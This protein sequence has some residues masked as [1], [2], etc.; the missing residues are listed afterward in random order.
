MVKERIAFVPTEE[1][2]VRYRMLRKRLVDEPGLVNISEEMREKLNEILDL[3]N[4]GYGVQLYNLIVEDCHYNVEVRSFRDR[5]KAIEIAKEISHERNKHPEYL[6]EDIIEGYEFHIT[7][8]CE[9]DC[10]SVV[11]TLLEK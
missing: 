1:Q 6:K 4:D 10:V 8:S 2:M 9:D 11:K 5:E 7:Y 3:Y